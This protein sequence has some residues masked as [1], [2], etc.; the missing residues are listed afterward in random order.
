LGKQPFDSRIGQCYIMPKRSHS[1]TPADFVRPSARNG[2]IM[3][4]N[5][6]VRDS[7]QCG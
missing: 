5:E 1:L 3:H 6:T 7:E 4:G 2:G